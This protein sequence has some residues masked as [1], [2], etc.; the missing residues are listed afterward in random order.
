MANVDDNEFDRES[1]LLISRFVDTANGSTDRHA[2]ASALV[3][4]HK[5]FVF[6][7]IKSRISNADVDTVYDL[8]QE[9]W[10]SL[11]SVRSLKGYEPRGRFRGYLH[12]SVD[13]KIGEW[14][15]RKYN[16]IKLEAYDDRVDAELSDKTQSQI[17]HYHD[18]ENVTRLRSI[19]GRISD[20]LRVVA[21]LECYRYVF[22]ERP[23]LD[24]VATVM[25]TN[26]VE[27]R[28]IL[29]RCTEKQAL[30]DMCDREKA[31]WISINYETLMRSNGG[32]NSSYAELLGLSAGSYR[33]RL[34]RARDYI[35]ASLSL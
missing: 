29:A 26:V 16:T 5:E 31:V 10:M 13:F 6:S 27:T 7:R 30:G 23:N 8:S 17:D 35:R 24:E 28:G 25:G 32:V 15:R 21:L 33:T 4:K 3:S 9:V 1:D 34:T 12:R 2:A 11:L 14:R 22:N 19:L 20:S 18:N